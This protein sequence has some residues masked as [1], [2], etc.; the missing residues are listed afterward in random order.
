MQRNEVESSFRA[1]QTDNKVKFEDFYKHYVDAKVNVDPIVKTL[2]SKFGKKS[3]KELSE[4]FDKFDRVNVFMQSNSGFLSFSE[5]SAFLK[6]T[7]QHAHK[8]DELE[9][10]FKRFDQGKHKVYLDSFIAVFN[11][12]H[13][14][15]K[16]LVAKIQDL[17]KKE[18]YDA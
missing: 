7:L 14:D 16:P 6:D 11:D 5:L 8:Q 4:L 2:R 15:L 9:M 18:G 13:L 17:M 10:L 12:S 1:M 3:D